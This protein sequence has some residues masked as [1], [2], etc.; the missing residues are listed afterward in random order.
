M[1]A[2]TEAIGEIEPG[3][4]GSEQGLLQ[5]TDLDRLGPAG[6]RRDAPPEQLLS[7]QLG[8]TRALPPGLSESPEQMRG[9]EEARQK[10]PTF[11]GH[12]HLRGDAGTG[13]T[14]TAVL[15]LLGEKQDQVEVT[16]PRY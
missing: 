10:P 15:H 8:A 6:S 9:R 16:G 4:H 7:E 14:T 1:D 13:G 3:Q 2:Y 11:D 12:Q 5:R